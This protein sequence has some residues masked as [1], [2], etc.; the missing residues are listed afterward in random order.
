MLAGV[1][2]VSFLVNDLSFHGQF[3]DIASFKAAILRLL[4]MRQLARQ[5]GYDL[6]CHKGMVNARVMPN[7]TM[8]Q[9]I[10]GLSFEEQRSLLSWFTKLG[11]FWD[12]FRNHSPNEY[13]ESSGAVVT[14]S[15]VGEAAWCRLIGID[16]DIVSL[17][18]SDWAFSPL[19]VEYH[20]ETAIPKAIEVVNHW[21]PQA[22]NTVLANKPV[23]ISTWSQLKAITAAR[24]SLL[25]FS[26]DV[27]AP[28]T[29][30]P[31]VPG[32][33]QRLL[34]ILEI[35]NKY[36][37][38]IDVNGKR[39]P[40]GQEIYQNFFTGVKGGGGHGATFKD[41][42]DTEKEEFKKQLTFK[43]PEDTNKSICCPWHGVV[44]TP[45]LRV[46]FSWPV[47]VDEPLYVVYVG[48]KLTKY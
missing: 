48:P 40:E 6:E 30:H 34:F 2:D 32:A 9:A 5:F 8:P 10:Q 3:Q 29:G 18:P 44:Q 19:P 35:L 1:R 42:S 38:C 20:C 17:T 39:T 31:F 21:D 46:H 41:S 43:H 28:L 36:K 24:C 23:P 33:A 25:T 4:E 11:P 12:D 14:D 45:Q 7:K 13:L 16:R 37:S 26:S 47:R 22:F 27:F 15:A